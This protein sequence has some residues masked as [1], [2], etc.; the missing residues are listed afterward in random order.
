MPTPRKVNGNS[1]GEWGF[2]SPV[3]LKESMRLKWNFQS[4]GEVA[5]TKKPSV[6]GVWIFSGATHCFYKFGDNYKIP[7]F[8]IYSKEAEMNSTLESFECM[9]FEACFKVHK[10]VSAYPKSTKLMVK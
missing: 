6:G 7:S 3:F 5:Q 8:S 2:K 1:K 10:L 9:D 4:G